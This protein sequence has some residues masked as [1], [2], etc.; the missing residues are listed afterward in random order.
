MRRYLPEGRLRQARHPL[1]ELVG[2][3][4][5]VAVD[6]VLDE[7]RLRLEIARTTDETR[8]EQHREDHADRD[9]RG[10]RIHAKDE[11]AACHDSGVA[12]ATEV[13]EQV[14]CATHGLQ[15]L[16]VAAVVAE[17]GAQA[18]DVDIDRAIEAEVGRALREIE[19]LLAG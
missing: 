17:L 11:N 8:R 1:G 14:P 18:R 13:R 10:Q 6:H 2:R 3:A 5:R 16:R 12:S 19:Q 7:R 9:R 15:D 4:G